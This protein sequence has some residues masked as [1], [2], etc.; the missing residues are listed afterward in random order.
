MSP[1]TR[2]ALLGLCLSPVVALAAEVSPSE[3]EAAPLPPELPGHLAAPAPAAA[4]RLESRTLPARI[5]A[6][7]APANRGGAA[8]RPTPAAGPRQLES[9]TLPARAPLPGA[10][11]GA[12]GDPGAPARPATATPPQGLRL[13]YAPQATQL[14]D[15]ERAALTRL[16]DSLGRGPGPRLAIHLHDATGPG[17]L[18][19]ALR[20][21]QLEQELAQLGVAANR[22]QFV[23]EPFAAG[24]APV[25][26]PHYVE[27][28]RLDGAR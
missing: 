10:G 12:G 23:A 19:R 24:S 4:T 5:P 18:L 1:N 25:L 14:A 9:N 16:V 13:Y 27:F 22:L 17:G 7:P 21:A 26:S 28:R 15:V 8:A 11:G 2:S 6:A 20:R 3:R